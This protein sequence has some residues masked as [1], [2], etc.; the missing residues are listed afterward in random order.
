MKSPN[1]DY[2]RLADHLTH[3]G[4]VERET[5]QHVLQQ[6]NATGALFP[7]ILVQE[8]LVSDWE[9]SRLCSELFHLPYLPI[10]SYPPNEEAREGLDLD[11][12]RQYALIPLDRFGDL[13][14]ISMPGVVPTSVLAAVGGPDREGGILPVV[15][16]VSENR[17]WIEENLPLAGAADLEAFTAALPEADASWANL[18]DE[19]DMAVK[20]ELE[21]G[22]GFDELDLGEIN[23]GDID[24][25]EPSPGAE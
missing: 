14:T 16:S 1:L 24:P 6:C 4:L 9:L 17:R 10:E 22:A 8:G 11:Y 5:V 15:G 19:A 7:E 23:L 21:G 12:L 13:L 25:G 20:Q 2:H 3:R 18:F